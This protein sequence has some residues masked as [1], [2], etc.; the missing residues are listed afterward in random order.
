MVQQV[1]AVILTAPE[2]GFEDGTST[3][4]FNLSVPPYKFARV[5][6]Q[7]L[8]QTTMFHVVRFGGNIDELYN[9]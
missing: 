5:S 6:L 7:T 3:T 9:I 8:C 1:R 4:T 2:S